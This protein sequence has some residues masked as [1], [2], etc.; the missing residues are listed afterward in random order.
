MRVT[1]Y[2][3]KKVTVTFGNHIATGLADDSFINI[4]PGGDG[5]TH[6]AGADGEVCVSI[7]PSSIYTIKVT[8]LQ[9]SKTNKF[10]RK[11]YDKMKEDGNGFFSVTIK[12]L[13]GKNK[14]SA[15]TGWVTKH[16]P[17]AYGK[18]QNNREW[19]IAVADG[20]ES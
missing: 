18:A 5:N 9:N 12:D 3:P 16:S 17:K 4:E 10:L 2:N 19:E 7:D 1:T 14:F 11:K 13:V 15:S 6:V 8:L 20:K